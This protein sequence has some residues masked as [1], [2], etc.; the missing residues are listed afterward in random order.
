MYITAKF[1]AFE[2]D[3]TVY[4]LESVDTF[5]I[6]AQKGEC[7]ISVDWTVEQLIA[8]MR[9]SEE[10]DDYG[11][12]YWDS[13]YSKASVE[14]IEGATDE[15][16]Y[17]CFREI[18]LSSPQIQNSLQEHDEDIDDFLQFRLGDLAEQYDPFEASEEM[19]EKFNEWFNL[20]NG[21]SSFGCSA[22]NICSFYVTSGWSAWELLVSRD[23]EGSELGSFQEVLDL[24]LQD[25]HQ[26]S[27]ILEKFEDRL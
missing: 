24:V 11:R 7:E 18:L 3:L 9:S 17:I 25:G 14:Y 10:S 1:S 6:Q 12:Y 4:Y 27:D 13:R 23:G 2:T 26:I 21:E 8:D 16:D 5:V 15:C 20:V 19:K 22:E